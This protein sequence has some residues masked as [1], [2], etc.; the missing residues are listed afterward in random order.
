MVNHTMRMKQQLHH[1]RFNHATKNEAEKITDCIWYVIHVDVQGWKESEESSIVLEGKKK[2]L[3]S[4]SHGW[5]K[6]R[7][8]TSAH[9]MSTEQ[10]TLCQQLHYEQ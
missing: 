4:K 5:K 8:E 3:K 7:Q 1:I 2:Q 10:V 6:N 9:H